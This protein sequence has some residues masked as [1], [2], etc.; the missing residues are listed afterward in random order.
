MIELIKKRETPGFLVIESH[1]ML[2]M[3]LGESRRFK[4]DAL[5]WRNQKE[6]GI[7]VKD[8]LKLSKGNLNTCC[9]QLVLGVFDFPF[10]T[11][12]CVSPHF[13]CFPFF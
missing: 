13:L 7:L 1:L 11:S 2:A 12:N 3:G 9:V 5:R 4:V 8:N 10:T 6:I